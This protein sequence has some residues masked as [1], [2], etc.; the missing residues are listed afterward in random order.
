MTDRLRVREAA[1]ADA[2]AL[3]RLRYDFRSS[4]GVP[5]EAE[6]EFV[7]RCASWMAARLGGPAW[8]A[9]VVESAEGEI[10]GSAWLGMM[11]KIP[12]P[13]EEA[14]HH[15]YITNVYVR[16]DFRGGAGSRLVSAATTWCESAGIHAA[17]LWPTERSAAL[18]RR[19]GFHE[20]AALLER[21]FGPGPN[22]HDVGDDR[23]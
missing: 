14:E 10:V 2:P 3:A 13:T 11:E 16:P 6:A 17:V 4:L 20:P 23:E 18:Y 1:A 22:R 7:A 15:A 9:W 5:V 12:N 21:E 8:K 19:H